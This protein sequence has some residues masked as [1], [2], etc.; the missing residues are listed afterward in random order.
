[1]NSIGV[2]QGRLLPKYNNRYQAHPVGFWEEEFIIASG[3]NLQY[4]EFIFDYNEFELN[5]LYSKIGINKIKEIIQKTSVGVRSVCA[6]F[7]MESPFHSINPLVVK[8]SQLVI[9]NLLTNIAELGVKELVIPCVDQSSLLNEN[10]FNRFIHNI[11]P[12]VELATLYN[13]NL[14]LE[15]DLHPII[16][17]QFLDLLPYNNITVNYDTGNSASLGFN[18]IEEFSIY[19]NRISDIHI[20]D[21]K[22]NSGSVFLGTGDV[23][24]DLF[25]D[26]LK[27][28]SYKSPF[29][30]QV[31][32]DDEGI[33]VFRKQLEI[34]NNLIQKFQ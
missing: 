23:K 24:F 14:A 13:I 26:A 7:F 6:D 30:L 3:L 16:F 25:F 33:S 4:I 12:I 1:M 17:G 9:S 8:Q 34:F 11:Q 27:S 2:M 22:L 20:K 28:I 19:G 29:I 31:Y 10:D 18:P 15:T 5:P 32:R 21:R